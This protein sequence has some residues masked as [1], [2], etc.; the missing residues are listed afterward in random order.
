MAGSVTLKRST[1]P[2]TTCTVTVL[3]QKYYLN[4]NTSL[5]DIGSMLDTLLVA[6]INE[7]RSIA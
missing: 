6:L 1:T 3:V 4:W 2:Y 7:Q 5:P